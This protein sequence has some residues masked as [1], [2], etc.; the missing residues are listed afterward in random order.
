MTEKRF[1]EITGRLAE[2]LKGTKFE[3]HVFAV[4]GSVR[5]YVMRSEIKDIDLVIDIENGGISLAEYLSCANKLAYPPVVYPTYGT[6]MFRLSDFPDVELEAVHTRGEQYHD[7][8]SRNPETHFAGIDEDCVRRDLTINALYY[9]IFRRRVLDPTGRGLSDIENH[10]V[11]T[12]NR[13]PYV[14]FD[15]D[16]LRILR[17]IRFAAKYGWKISES[18]YNAMSEYKDRLGIISRERVTQEF[19]NML[20]TD[21]PHLAMETVCELGLWECVTGADMTPGM[22]SAAVSALREC[23]K[24]G[25]PL[26]TKLAV[27]YHAFDGRCVYDILHRLKFSNTDAKNVSKL[28]AHLHDFDTDCSDRQVRLSQVKFRSNRFYEL[29]YAMLALDTPNARIAM[30]KTRT[31]VCNMFGY[32]LPLDG[33]DIIKEL[34]IESGAEVGAILDEMMLRACETPLVTKSELLEPFRNRFGGV[35]ATLKQE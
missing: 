9:D 31:K 24:D 25:R 28:V 14:V 1:I 19:V 3:S 27:I 18:T 17:V 30:R 29:L 7:R 33:N 5:D 35:C 22:C 34:G 12:S 16:P 4:G 11:R 13:N 8:N 20:N 23:A 15:D 32:R 2:L 21:N 10:I 26:Y 6:C